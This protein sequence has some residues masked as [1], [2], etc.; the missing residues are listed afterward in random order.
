MPSCVDK[1]PSACGRKQN[2]KVDERTLTLE[3]TNAQLRQQIAERE[4]AETERQV[5]QERLMVTLSSIGDGV[6]TIDTAGR[7]VL[8]NKVAQQ[9]GRWAAATQRV[10][11]SR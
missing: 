2:G 5:E 4:R 3:E 1:S 6:I 11:A 8:L 10:S 7:V 9:S